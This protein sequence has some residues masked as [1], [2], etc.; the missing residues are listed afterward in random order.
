MDYFASLGYEV[1]A[2][3]LP[4]HGNSSLNKGHINFYSFGE[5]VNV[6][7]GEVEKISP[8]P[9]LIGH[10]L[11]G[12]ITQKYL[13]SHQLPG[14]ALLASL[15]PVGMYPMFVRMLRRY[16][17]PTLKALL[18]LNVYEW[19]RTPEMARDLF[20]SPQADVDAA[21][22]HKQ[23]VRE[24]MNC[25]RLMLPLNKVNPNRSPV[26][27]ISGEKDVVFTVEEENLTAK[28]YG[29]R[30]IVMKGQAHNLMMEPLWKET[31][32]AI[33]Q[34]IVHELKLP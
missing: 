33:D 11:G 7:A 15:P 3:S 16:P 32:D 27:V 29:A 1:H 31:A 23:L 24:S 20:L 22:F 6:L 5:Y 30:N 34:W 4:G 17:L 28:K 25:M 13:E 9:V 14:A 8:A 19:V 2:I 21:A 12:A 18:T 10:S 26:L